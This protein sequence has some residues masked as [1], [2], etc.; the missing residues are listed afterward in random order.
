MKKYEVSIVVRTITSYDDKETIK[1]K[2]IIEA[3]SEKQA[4]YFFKKKHSKE[5]K[6][7][8]KSKDSTLISVNEFFG[9]TER[10]YLSI[11]LIKN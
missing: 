6:G 4:I 8:I 1:I 2:E 9:G 5:C 7:N 10:I 3:V 11:K